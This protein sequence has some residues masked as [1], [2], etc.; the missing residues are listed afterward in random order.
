[1]WKNRGNIAK[2]FFIIF[3]FSIIISYSFALCSLEHD[4]IGEGCNICYEIN[5]MKSVFD[6]LLI[7]SLLYIFIKNSISYIVR[8]RYIWQINYC[9]TPVKLKVKLS[10]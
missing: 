3:V 2:L 1:M 10:E 6:N 4:C 8:L 7:L 9:L 5:L